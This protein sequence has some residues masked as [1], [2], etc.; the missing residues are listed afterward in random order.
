MRLRGNAVGGYQQGEQNIN[1]F[2]CN[3][4]LREKHQFEKELSMKA[5]YKRAK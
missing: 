2:K 1:L 5:K 4:L 3:E